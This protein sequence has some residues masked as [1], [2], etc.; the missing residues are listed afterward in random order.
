MFAYIIV[1]VILVAFCFY[2][3]YYTSKNNQRED[4]ESQEKEQQ[5]LDNQNIL[6]PKILSSADFTPTSAHDL[7]SIPINKSKTPKSLLF[8]LSVDSQSKRIALTD[9]RRDVKTAFIDFDK[10]LSCEVLFGGQSTNTSGVG[11]GSG[12][13]GVGFA[14]SDST[15][16]NIILKFTLKDIDNP[17][18]EVELINHS[19]TAIINSS[20]TTTTDEFYLDAIKFVEK[21]GSVVTNILDMK[22]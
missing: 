19:N 4:N 10:I 3:V 5:I 16:Q 1:P 9:I 8:R 2:M 6:L 13:L 11:A 17:T 14:S 18:H 22:K 12:G 7:I 15:V 20:Y 21:V